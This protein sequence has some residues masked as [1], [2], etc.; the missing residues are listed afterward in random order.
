[1]VKLTNVLV[2]A[3]GLAV[4]AFSLER[5]RVGGQSRAQISAIR[6]P[7]ASPAIHHSRATFLKSTE[8]AT[9]EPVVVAAAVAAPAPVT[10]LSK[11]WNEQT[12]LG[13]YLAV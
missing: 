7:S 9:P 4:T 12:K 3:S 5:A 13:A 6:Q 11:V 8:G 10:L 2:L 1:M